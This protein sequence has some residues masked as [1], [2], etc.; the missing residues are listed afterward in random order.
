MGDGEPRPNACDQ[1]Q[2]YDNLFKPRSKAWLAFDILCSCRCMY[3]QCLLSFLP[4]YYNFSQA[5]LIWGKILQFRS[6]LSLMEK[7]EG[8]ICSCSCAVSWFQWWSLCLCS[9]GEF[10]LVAVLALF[11]AL[12]D[13]RNIHLPMISIFTW[14]IPVRHFFKLTMDSWLWEKI[15]NSSSIQDPIANVPTRCYAKWRATVNCSKETT[16]T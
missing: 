6:F 4:K 8:Q 11:S 1:A 13:N 5:G 2:D 7:K 3:L 16:R 12:Q 9:N 10:F 14:F 15:C